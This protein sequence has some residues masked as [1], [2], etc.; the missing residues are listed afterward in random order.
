MV[1][2]VG[3]HSQHGLTNSRTR[4]APWSPYT[5]EGLTYTTSRFLNSPQVRHMGG[6]ARRCLPVIFGSSVE[7]STWAWTSAAQVPAMPH[8]P[9]LCW[10][11]EEVFA[12]PTSGPTGGRD[13]EV[14]RPRR[15]RISEFLICPPNHK[16]PAEVGL[17]PTSDPQTDPA[18]SVTKLEIVHDETGL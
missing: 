10:R 7:S 1:L 6:A 18:I 14:S 2:S 13:G 15:R 11:L 12:F 3:L 9:E 5:P 8:R 17:G 16:L 4:F